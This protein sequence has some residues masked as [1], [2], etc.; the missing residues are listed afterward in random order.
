[1]KVA[2]G[3]VLLFTHLPVDLGDDVNVRI[4]ALGHAGCQLV[5]E[6]GATNGRGR[7]G[8]GRMDADDWDSK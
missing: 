6:S 4:D 8:T 1:M 3:R 2:R 7:T 5:R